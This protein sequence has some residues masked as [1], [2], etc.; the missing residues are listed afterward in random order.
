MYTIREISS[1][2]SKSSDDIIQD[3]ALIWGDATSPDDIIQSSFIE[4]M[5]VVSDEV[6]TLLDS[7]KLREKDVRGREMVLDKRQ[8][9]MD[10]KEK[11]IKG[12]QSKVQSEF[13]KL[14]QGTLKTVVTL[15]NSI[16]ELK[17][18]NQRLKASFQSMSKNHNDMK[19]ELELVQS[20]NAKL[21]KQLASA[22][23]RIKNL[24][25]LQDRK[26]KELSENKENI[27]SPEPSKLKPK[28]PKPTTPKP[29]HSSFELSGMLMKVLSNID[30]EHFTDLF[31]DTF[32]HQ[33]TG[34]LS[35]LTSYLR[36]VAPTSAVIQYP[37][38]KL[39]LKC[40]SVMNETEVNMPSVK[41][42]FRKISEVL[43]TEN[44]YSFS[45]HL[46]CRLVSCLTLSKTSLQVFC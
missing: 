34:L 37:C 42:I 1:H 46:H 3:G 36:Q 11:E 24:L 2:S 29:D 27:K 35:S 32:Q 19:T 30:Q 12:L 33:I 4:E 14:E 18:E 16:L 9:R 23:G 7:L 13:E 25:K 40:V 8:L 5:S 44:H 39:L 31:E 38:L 17:K 43:C 10:L 26:T 15:E 22:N 20:K 21:E 6:R 41:V 45:P 28:K